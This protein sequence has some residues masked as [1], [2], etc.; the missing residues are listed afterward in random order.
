MDEKKVNN[1]GFLDKRDTNQ[2]F[3]QSKKLFWSFV[4][5]FMEDFV[6]VWLGYVLKSFSV[7]H[8]GI[9]D[10]KYPKSWESSL[11]FSQ[12]YNICPIPG[13][14]S[15]GLPSKIFWMFQEGASPVFS[16]TQ[17]AVLPELFWKMHFPECFNS[18]AAS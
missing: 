8:F 14:S 12:L 11:N 17:R 9:L 10:Q 1:S 4:G 3:I 7:D 6:R 5:K 2:E 15:L 13:S 16:G 18:S